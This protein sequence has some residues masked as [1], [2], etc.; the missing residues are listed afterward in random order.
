MDGRGHH[1]ESRLERLAAAVTIFAVTL[2]VVLLAVRSSVSLVVPVR[3]DAA[4][5]PAPAHQRAAAHQELRQAER[6][7]IPR[8]LAPF[9]ATRLKA[10]VTVFRS[11][12]KIC[13]Q[14]IAVVV[15]PCA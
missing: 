5:F 3:Q 2:P 14:H 10:L 8:Q 12:T 15:G 1:D 4:A 13:M 6:I 11:S 9:V 7:V